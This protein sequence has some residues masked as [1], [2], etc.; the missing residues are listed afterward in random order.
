MYENLGN[1]QVVWVVYPFSIIFGALTPNDE[2]DF[3]A[4]KSIALQHCLLFDCDRLPTDNATD[5][6]NCL[7]TVEVLS[8][9]LGVS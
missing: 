3:E 7:R 8:R 5:Q 6:E 9:V 1:E 2:C 4:Q